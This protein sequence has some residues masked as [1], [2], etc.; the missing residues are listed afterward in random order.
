MG[1][2]GILIA[3]Q[4]EEIQVVKVPK[5]GPPPVAS[6]QESA[7]ASS[8]TAAGSVAGQVGSASPMVGDVPTASMT[9]LSWTVPDGW[10][11]KEARAPRLATFL[12]PG[13]GGDADFSVTA[14]P[15]DV[16]GV[17]ANVNRWRQQLGLGPASAQEIQADLQPVPTGLGDAL[18]VRIDGSGSS[19]LAAILPQPGRTVFFRL[20]GPTETIA[21]AHSSVLTLLSSLKMGDTP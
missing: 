12:V 7:P 8:A 15:G 16:G 4:S 13:P 5:E 3:C 18:L 19:T 11:P 17:V 10:Q 1:L 9:G 2:C 20:N 6:P 21:A 14:F